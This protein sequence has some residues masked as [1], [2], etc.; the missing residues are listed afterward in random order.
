MES[1]LEFFKTLINPESIIK[2][3]GLT[4]LLLVVFAETGLFFGF[5]LPG[6]SLLFIAGLLCAASEEQLRVG[7]VPIFN[8]SIYVLLFSVMIAAVL[9]DFVGYW[10]GR[11]TGP[12]LFKRDD[13]LFFKKRYV[14]MA[15]EFYKKHGAMALILGRFIPIIRTFAPI[16]AGVVQIEFKRFV[17][18]NVIGAVVWAASMILAGY[19]LGRSFPQIKDYLEYIVIGIILVSMIPVFVTFLRQRLVKRTDD[20][21][22]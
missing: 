10:F 12:M 21:T 2:Y 7:E 9:G 16:I 8:V 19:F 1:F 15:D 18:Y 22:N 3:G 4:L 14:H 20:H 13:T 6:D 17:T 5:F 11:R